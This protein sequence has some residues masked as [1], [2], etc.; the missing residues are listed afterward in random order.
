MN[1]KEDA[2]LNNSF[3]YSYLKLLCIGYKNR[4]KEAREF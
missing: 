4:T 2:F 1:G 3:D